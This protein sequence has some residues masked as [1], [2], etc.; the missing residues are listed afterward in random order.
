[1]TEHDLYHQW[2][3]QKRDAAVPNDFVDQA[4]KVIHRDTIK[5]HTKL[6][7]WF[8]HTPFVQAGLAT[9]ALGFL[10]MRFAVLFLVAVG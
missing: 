7:D 5:H 4:M 6:W 3:K 2:L 10:V 9:A 8:V 1:M